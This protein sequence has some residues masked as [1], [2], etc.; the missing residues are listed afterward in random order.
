MD[1]IETSDIKSDVFG[2]SLGLTAESLPRSASVRPPLRTI[3]CLMASDVLAV[4]IALLAASALRD[5]A[6]RTPAASIFHPLLA[7]LPL[8]LCSLAAVGLYPG[9]TVNP[10]EELRLCAVA[11]TLAFCG[12]WSATLFLHDLNQSRLIYV[13]GYALAVMLV[14]LLRSMVRE[15]FAT[16]P[17]WGSQVAILGYGSTG[18]FVHETLTRNPGIGLKAVAVLDDNPRQYANAGHDLL[19]GPLS[20]CQEITGSRKI[21]Y[22]ILCMPNLSRH[23]LLNFLDLHGQCFGHVIVIP[24]LIGMTSLGISARE[25]GGVVGLEVRRQLLR[26]SARIAKRVLDLAIALLLAPANALL[27][28]LFAILIK[29]E[30]GGPVF[31]ADERVGRGG[32][33]FRRHGNCAA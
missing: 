13:I 33:K 16:R 11:I 14:P 22:G 19:R 15:M 12:L 27:V 5:M 32:K 18:K 21:P 31:Y 1:L 20:S 26:P 24:N 2:V 3:A 30:D 9:V 10:V 6:M 17:W 25:V 28:A 23:E 7:A 4:V 29:L 8:A